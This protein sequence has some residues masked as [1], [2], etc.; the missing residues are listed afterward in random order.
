MARRFADSSSGG[1]AFHLHLFPEDAPGCCGPG[2]EVSRAYFD[3]HRGN[4][5]RVGRQP[6]AE[7]NVARS[8]PDKIGVLGP[9]VVSA[10][11]IFVDETDREIL[12]RR[13]V[14]CVHNPSSNMML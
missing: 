10:H 14:G 4:E 6:E 5:E 8:I 11:C 1:A 3:S 12:A 13:Q 9:D 2:E 7:R